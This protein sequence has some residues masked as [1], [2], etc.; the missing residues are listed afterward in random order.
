MNKQ[1]LITK[2]YEAS[3]GELVS[4]ARGQ[5]AALR[6]SVAENAVRSREAADFEEKRAAQHADLLVR[7]KAR[8]DRDVS[9]ET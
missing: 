9:A 2:T 8:E 5:I 7:R 4:Q 1:T 3:R 6:I